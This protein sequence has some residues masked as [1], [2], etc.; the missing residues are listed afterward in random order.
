M[1]KEYGT[2]AD[3]MSKIDA[4]EAKAAAQTT[5]P[6]P[7]AKRRTATRGEIKVIK[8]SATSKPAEAEAAE[9]V[10]E[11]KPKRE[12]KPK[13]SA[14]VRLF[15][16]HLKTGAIRL[17]EEHQSYVGYAAADDPVMLGNNI[18]WIVK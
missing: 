18:A 17:E 5:A 2:V 15:E 4:A 13:K 1:A 6:K 10:A 11:A 8:P 14:A 3:V 16:K 7:K 9:P 12:P